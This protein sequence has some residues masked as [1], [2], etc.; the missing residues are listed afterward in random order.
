MIDLMDAF[1]AAYDHPIEG[2]KDVESY[3]LLTNT[4]P[5]AEV[6]KFAIH[7]AYD[8]VGVSEIIATADNGF[9]D[10]DEIIKLGEEVLKTIDANPAPQG[11]HVEMDPGTY[12]EKSQL[13]DPSKLSTPQE[14][15]MV[16]DTQG[17]LLTIGRAEY[18]AK[19]LARDEDGRLLVMYHGTSRYGFTTFNGKPIFL[20]DRGAAS[21]TYFSHTDAAEQTAEIKVREKVGNLPRGDEAMESA[22]EGELLELYKTAP[23]KTTGM[24]KATAD[25]RSR[26]GQADLSAHGVH[27]TRGIYSL[28]LRHTSA[29]RG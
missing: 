28:Y 16:T 13:V 18:F 14:K 25:L 8:K 15:R 4:F 5:S 1:N 7:N 24:D 9:D 26:T 29:E 3:Y 10:D 22:V 2:A 6:A 11:E 17:T 19:S 20:A 12:H 21:L 23:D 27:T